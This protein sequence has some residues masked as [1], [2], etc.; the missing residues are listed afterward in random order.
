MFNDAYGGINMATKILRFPSV[1][2]RTGLPRSTIYDKISKGTFPPP[3]SLGD[4]AVGWIESEIEEWLTKNIEASRK[5]ANGG[6]V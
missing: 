4:R 2:D 3:I 5:P 1:K 6:K